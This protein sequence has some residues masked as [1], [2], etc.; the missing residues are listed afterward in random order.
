[1][2]VAGKSSSK[3]QKG[4]RYCV[5]KSGTYW[6]RS[7]LIKVRHVIRH[8]AVSHDTAIPNPATNKYSAVRVTAFFL[9][10]FP[11][12]QQRFAPLR[13]SLFAVKIRSISVKTSLCLSF[14]DLEKDLVLLCNSLNIITNP[15]SYLIAI[16]DN[17]LSQTVTFASRIKPIRLL[18]GIFF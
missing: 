16:L 18:Q 13:Q 2:P 5:N 8:G 14:L 17:H 10:E 9:P 3:R 1:M 7:S 4:K 12:A 6:S 11:P 15:F